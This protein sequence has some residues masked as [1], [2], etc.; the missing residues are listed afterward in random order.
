MMTSDIKIPWYLASP[1]EE[2]DR[3]KL[4]RYDMR[5][6]SSPSFEDAMEVRICRTFWGR[7]C[8]A[9]WLLFTNWRR[10]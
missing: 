4:A 5:R 9:C 8:G 6:P 2:P 10:S 1:D 3:M 7:V